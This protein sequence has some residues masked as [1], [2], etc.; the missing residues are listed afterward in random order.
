MG[1]GTSIEENVSEMLAHLSF[2]SRH[3]MTRLALVYRV[4]FEIIVKR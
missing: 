3:R 1:C 2:P 4:L